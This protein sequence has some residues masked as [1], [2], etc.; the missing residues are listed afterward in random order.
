MSIGISDIFLYYCVKPAF[1]INKQ[2]NCC[3]QRDMDNE[4]S[5]HMAESKTWA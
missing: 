1:R 5:Q 3:Q 2:T 4:V